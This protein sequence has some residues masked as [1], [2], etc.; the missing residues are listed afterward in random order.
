M[1]K[2]ENKII[3]EKVLSYQVFLYCCF[4]G[5]DQIALKKKQYCFEA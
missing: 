5:F 3:V 2:E 4:H 1:E